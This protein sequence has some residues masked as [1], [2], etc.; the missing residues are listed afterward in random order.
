MPYFSYH[1]RNKKLI[2][3]ALLSDYFYQEKNDK[4]FLVLVF[5]NG[6]QFPVK[7]ERWMEYSKFI[8]DYYCKGEEKD[9]KSV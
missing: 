7:E 6:K 9:E 5:K 8:K 1:G 3:Q 2:K 4:V